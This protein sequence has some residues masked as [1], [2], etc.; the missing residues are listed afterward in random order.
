MM[1]PIHYLECQELMQPL[2]RNRDEMSP[3]PA[4]A[5]RNIRNAVVAE[6]EINSRAGF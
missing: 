3:A 4:E 6:A 2:Q 1:F 5:A